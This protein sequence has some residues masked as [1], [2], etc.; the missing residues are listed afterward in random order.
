VPAMIAGTSASTGSSPGKPIS[1]HTPHTPAVPSR[2]SANSIID[3]GDPSRPRRSQSRVRSRGQETEAAREEDSSDTTTRTETGTTAIDI[4]R[5]PRA[6]TYGTRSSSVN[7]RQNRVEEEE[8]EFVLR[9]ASLPVDERV[10]LSLSEL[11]GLESAA[12]QMENSNQEEGKA[13]ESAS[14]EEQSPATSG[15]E[16][17]RRAYS[18]TPGAPALPHRLRLSRNS[19]SLRGSPMFL[20]S[21]SPSGSAQGPSSATERFTPNEHGGVG[22]R[23]SPSSRNSVA[24]DDDEGFIFAMSEIGATG[25]RRS[26][27]E[28]RGGADRR[29][30]RGAGNSSNWRG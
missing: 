3:Y 23:N 6:W 13:G 20:N 5:S 10:D 15:L 17:P 7:Q 12:P 30:G 24:Q 29:A 28:P 21:Y 19:L 9:S 16:A 27:E 2:L 1:P 4:P 26:G 8:P 14:S 25:S 22:A 18:A 11:R